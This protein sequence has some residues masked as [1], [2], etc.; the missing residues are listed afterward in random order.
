MKARPRLQGRLATA[1]LQAAMPNPPSPLS[2]PTLLPSRHS[3]DNSLVH[4]CVLFLRLGFDARLLSGMHFCIDDCRLYAAMLK[5]TQLFCL[6]MQHANWQMQALHTEVYH[7]QSQRLLSCTITALPVSTHSHIKSLSSLCGYTVCNKQFASNKPNGVCRGL[8]SLQARQGGSGGSRGNPT[9]GPTSDRK[10]TPAP[11]RHLSFHQSS[12]HKQRSIS[13][14]VTATSPMAHPEAPASPTMSLPSPRPSGAAQHSPAPG[15]AALRSPSLSVPSPRPAR[16][17]PS[18]PALGP[19]P[20]HPSFST[21]SPDQNPDS[22]VEDLLRP[23]ASK[24][25]DDTNEEEERHEMAEVYVLSDM[26]KVFEQ[27]VKQVRPHLGTVKCANSN[28]MLPWL[29]HGR[30]R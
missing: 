7:Q 19:Q 8:V 14:R 11:A 17:A 15:H 28:S 1:P 25:G 21:M 3:G 23:P 16:A 6:S 20:K 2:S 4:F 13:D 24:A 30:C 18:S 29:P 10:A 26:W 12:P 5:Q 27:T 22:A 9:S